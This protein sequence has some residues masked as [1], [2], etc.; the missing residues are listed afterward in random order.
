M[1]REPRQT[2][3]EK[4]D[5]I[6]SVLP[7]L[8]EHLE[9]IQ[10]VHTAMERVAPDVSDGLYHP[11]PNPDAD[12]AWVRV[13]RDNDWR[14]RLRDVVTAWGGDG[15]RPGLLQ[16]H[17]L[18]AMAVYYQHIEPFPEWEP[19]RRWELS[20]A[21]V[22]W[23]ATDPEHGIKGEMAYCQRTAVVATVGRPRNLVDR[24]QV[25][26]RMAYA[27]CT[28]RDITERAECSRRDVGRV[29]LAHGFRTRAAETKGEG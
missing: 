24:D 28:W 8:H 17:P 27:G 9:L 16:I 20:E 2:P 12:E 7:L 22:W 21:G 15:L 29:L 11:P 3:E 6:K 23:M 10:R 26:V 18:L 5:A 25:I 4:C 13:E 19:H 1:S 14:W